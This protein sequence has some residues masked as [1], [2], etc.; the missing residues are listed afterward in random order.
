VW[1][2]LAREGSRRARPDDATEEEEEEEEEE[3]ATDATDAADA[4]PARISSATS[5]ARGSV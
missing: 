3:E 1:I 2:S 4:T 5:R